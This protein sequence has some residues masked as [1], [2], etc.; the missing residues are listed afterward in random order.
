MIAGRAREM[1][2]ESERHT[3]TQP[4]PTAGPD[5]NQAQNRCIHSQDFGRGL[6]VVGVAFERLFLVCFGFVYMRFGT[7]RFI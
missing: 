1:K 6:V 4:T 2:N 7:R 3:H 5:F